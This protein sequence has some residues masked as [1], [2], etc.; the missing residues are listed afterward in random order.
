[1]TLLFGASFAFH[2]EATLTGS[3][4]FSRR[5]SIAIVLMLIVLIAGRI[6]PSFT[7][8]WLT[9][10][11]ER[12]P[13]YPHRSEP[14][15][16][17]SWRR[18]GS[19]TVS[20]SPCRTLRRQVPHWRS[21]PD[22]TSSGCPAGRRAPFAQF[23]ARHPAYRRPLGAAGLRTDGR[24]EPRLRGAGRRPP[25]LD[26]QS[27]RYHDA[28]RNV[29]L[30]PRPHRSTSGSHGLDPILLC[31]RRHRHGRANLLSARPWASRSAAS[32]WTELVF[33]VSRFFAAAYWQ[34]LTRPRLAPKTA[35][36]A[37]QA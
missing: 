9:P 30:Q 3:A 11:W 27:L 19:R 22:F 2:I 6:V 20:G 1:M 7:R 16:R 33:G 14:M 13:T 8:N 32:R 21:A 31:H 17:S 26:R 37:Q 10:R 34:V 24:S 35:S 23:P 12:T 36:A 4:E 29:P 5:A 18:A 15:T 25:C 28:H